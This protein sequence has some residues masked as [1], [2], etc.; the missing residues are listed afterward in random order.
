M[1]NGH[2]V[3]RGILVNVVEKIDCVYRQ[4]KKNEERGGTDY[5][6]SGV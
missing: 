6:F 3:D 5:L 4:I 1:A 2:S